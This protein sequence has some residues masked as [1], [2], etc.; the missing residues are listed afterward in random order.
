MYPRLLWVHSRA[1][2]VRI[3]PNGREVI[4]HPEFSPDSFSPA[5]FSSATS[6][7]PMT[8]VPLGEGTVRLA[9]SA[10]M[11]QDP[12]G[13]PFFLPLQKCWESEISPNLTTGILWC[14]SQGRSRCSG[15]LR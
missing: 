3:A 9:C 12:V 14:V 7:S 5:S 2:R 1:R 13:L 4:N 10:R 11:V 8:G 15:P 6:S